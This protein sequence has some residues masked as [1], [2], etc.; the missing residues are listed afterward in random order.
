MDSKIYA[1]INEMISLQ[2][3]AILTTL[4][5]AT[6]GTPRKL[7]AKM[8]VMSD[9]SILGTIG[10]GMFEKQVIDEALK[11]C[12]TGV[13]V[14]LN[15]DLSVSESEVGAVCGG[16]V[17]IFLE[18]IIKTSKLFIL[19][20][21]HVG[22][23]IAEIAQYLDFSI[24]VIDDRPEWAN[25]DNYPMEC[26]LWTEDMLKSAEEIPVDKD[27]YIII[28]TRSWKLDEGIFK[29]LIKKDYA[30]LGI[31]GSK[32]K[33]KIH[34][35]NLFAEGYTED[36]FKKVYGPIGLPIG[37]Y[38]PHEIAISILAEIIAV[39]KGKRDKLQGWV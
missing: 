26:K 21:G 37:A 10:G 34:R 39:M 25:R 32:N 5:N 20:G 1:K 12:E 13:P 35:D 24:N 9:G 11:V 30:Y 3:Q 31:I 18:P 19:G 22:K 14:L 28:L 7:G 4:V 6:E 29:R 8:L 27:S 2:K 38:S 23:A 15:K 16:Q 17:S 36:D 33:I